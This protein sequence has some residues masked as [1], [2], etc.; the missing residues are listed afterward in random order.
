MKA[1]FLSLCAV[2]AAVSLTYLGH[3]AVH[4]PVGGPETDRE[5]ILVGTGCGPFGETLVAREEDEFPF[6][7]ER[8][9]A[10]WIEAAR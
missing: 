2:M 7:C 9:D 10:H 3:V 4:G 5:T 8:I 6:S 1:A